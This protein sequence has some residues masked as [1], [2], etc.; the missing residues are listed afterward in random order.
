[1]ERIFVVG[2]GFMGSGIAQVCA[3]AGYPTHLMDVDPKALEKARSGIEWSVEKLWT[4]DLLKDRPEI[5]LKRIQFEQEL[6][7]AGKADWVIEAALEVADLKQKI[8]REM[9]RLLPQETI[10]ATNTSSVPITLISQAV[11]HP[12]RVLGLHF[13]GPVPMMKLVEVVKGEKTS[14]QVIERSMTFVRSL[15]KVPILVKKDVPGFVMNRIFAAALRESMDLVTQGV[16]SLD[17]LDLGMRL[18]YG[19]TAGPFE[20][21]DNAGLDTWVLIEQAL[22]AFGEEHLVSRSGLLE[23]MVKRGRLGRKVGKGFYR[24]SEDNKRLLFEKEDEV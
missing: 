14:P 6:A 22:K 19:W 4:K 12:E 18:G 24:Y 23:R 10:L 11:N 9:D 21:T 20:I 5:I 1:M 7:N 13:F 16:V 3:Q 15:G 8:F 2:A 17:D